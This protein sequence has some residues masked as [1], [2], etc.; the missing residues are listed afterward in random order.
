M[1]QRGERWE[2]ATVV[3]RRWRLVTERMGREIAPAMW[4]VGSVWAAG[5][6]GGPAGV[7]A[8]TYCWMAGGGRVVEQ[9]RAGER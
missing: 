7:E 3:G 5:C 9:M 6:V 4:M 1:R 8:C 2:Q